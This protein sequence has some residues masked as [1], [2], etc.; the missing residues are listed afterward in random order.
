MHLGDGVPN[1][2][3]CGPTYWKEACGGATKSVSAMF[4]WGF[5]PQKDSDKH[6]SSLHVMLPIV[7]LQQDRQVFHR[8]F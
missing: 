8:E 1:Y 5:F 6:C 3:I 2:P 7:I 4:F